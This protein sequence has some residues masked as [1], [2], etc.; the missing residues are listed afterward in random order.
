MAVT[1]SAPNQ[2]PNAVNDYYILT[3]ADNAPMSFVANVRAN[4]TDPEGH[5][6][7]LTSVSQPTNGAST[8]VVR[9]SVT[10]TN[11]PVG[12][13]VFSYT[14]SDGHGGTDTGSV[15]IS[16]TYEPSWCGGPGQ[17]ICP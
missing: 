8:A 3:T 15:T 9:G 14:I 4:D 5:A 10:V 6:I 17:P 12:N 1:V 13:T 16:R 7:T 2:P 11:L